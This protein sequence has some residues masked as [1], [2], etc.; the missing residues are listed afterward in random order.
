MD[1]IILIKPHRT[2]I[3][4][5]CSS[6]SPDICAASGSKQEKTF[7]KIL[8]DDGRLSYSHR[9]PGSQF[10][11]V[12]SILCARSRI[13]G[14]GKKIILQRYFV[15]LLGFEGRQIQGVHFSTCGSKIIRIFVH[16]RIRHYCCTTY[17]TSC[18]SHH[19]L[20]Q[21]KIQQYS[22]L[23]RTIIPDTAGGTCFV[24]FSVELLLLLRHTAVKKRYMI[25]QLLML[26]H[27]SQN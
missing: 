20:K 4:L 25:R 19:Q 12:H 2:N 6:I 5:P 11:R 14:W 27:L 13:R 15:L 10:R 24:F 26:I 23:L 8:C 22:V 18:T 17:H 9:S 1:T 7:I 21:T 3:V 16:T